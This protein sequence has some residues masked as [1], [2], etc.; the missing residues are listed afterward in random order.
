[1]RVPFVDLTREASG[2]HNEIMEKCDEVIQSG[3]FISGPNVK[4]FE[5]KVANYLKVR[6]VISVGNGSDALVFIL[7]SLGIGS[8]DEV[9][10]P[11]NSFIASGWAIEAVGA[12]PIFCDVED[13]FLISKKSV[14]SHISRRTKA[15]MAVHLTGRVVD[16]NWLT[17][18][19][20]EYGIEIVEDAA[21]AFGAHN[22][23][24]VFAGAMGVA[25]AISLHPL[26]NLSVCGDGGLVTTNSNEMAE[27]CK[28]LRNHGLISRDEAKIWG[29]NSRLDEIQAAIGLVKMNYIDEWLERY[30]EIA[31]IYDQRLSDKIKKPKI[32]RQT[33]DVY[34]NYVICVDSEIRDTMQEYLAREGVETKVH[35]PIP[36]HMQECA[37]SSRKVKVSLERTEKLAKEMISLPIYP[38]LSTAEIIHVANT[39]NKACKYFSGK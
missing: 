1:M 16:F 4:R 2:C 36:I 28:L 38:N 9:I 15:I 26:K 3:Q 25:G 34:H 18:L 32:R 27:N 30:I 6:H 33:K 39:V 17:E 12:T 19:A 20:S 35:Y 5:E 7:R 21:Q 29:F 8:N 37:L 13:D 14:Q 31:N 11:S 24:G 23:K 10:C 22:E